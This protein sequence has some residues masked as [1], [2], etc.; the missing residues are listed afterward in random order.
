MSIIKIKCPLCGTSMRIMNNNFSN[1]K[2]IKCLGC[3]Q[4]LT[5]SEFTQLPL[6]NTEVNSSD[7]EKTRI[8]SPSNITSQNASISEETLIK[9]VSSD[10]PNLKVGYSAGKAIIGSIIE[11]STSKKYFLKE[12][13]NTLGRKSISSFVSIPIDTN[14]RYMSR[15]HLTIEVIN[16]GKE[17]IHIAY[18]CKDDV[19][20]YINNKVLSVS[21]QIVLENG[22]SIQM[23]DTKFKFEL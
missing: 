4:V 15:N 5:F 6:N 23:G 2:R 14:D 19:E 12:G 1:D 9:S 10:I 16:G 11:Q 7:N 20:T 17:Y 3:K 8:P 18:N 13:K 22:D 21:D